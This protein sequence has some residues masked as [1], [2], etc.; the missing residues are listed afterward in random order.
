MTGKAVTADASR[1]IMKTRI[2][3]TKDAT[4]NLSKWLTVEQIERLRV[5]AEDAKHIE[6]LDHDE[7]SM[8]GQKLVLKNASELA[9]GLAQILERAPPKAK[10]ELTQI[11][12][13]QLGGIGERGTMVGKLKM[14]AKRIDLRLKEIPQGRRKSHELLVSMIASVAKDAGVNPSAT[15]KS[16]FYK[17]CKTVFEAA[18]IHQSPAAGIRLHIG[19]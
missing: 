13:F 8:G 15:E 17:I 3:F 5:C 9:S 1:D 7:P 16:R 6:K 10:A 12:H 4:T 14:L 11:F 18:G 2:Q 19:K